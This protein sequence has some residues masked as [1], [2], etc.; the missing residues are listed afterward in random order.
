MTKSPQWHNDQH[1][2]INSAGWSLMYNNTLVIHIGNNWLI[3][4]VRQQDIAVEIN[5]INAEQWL[6]Y[7]VNTF[8]T[9]IHILRSVVS[10]VAF[11]RV[12]TVVRPCCCR[13]DNCE[14][15]TMT[16]LWSCLHRVTFARLLMTFSL[17]ES[18]LAAFLAVICYINWC[19]T[20]F[21]TSTS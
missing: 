20:Y 18:A 16:L 3:S 12:F 11:Y 4:F 21:F 2:H 17:S 15:A 10:L 7:T 19:V 14:L 5:A 8:S 1:R 6:Q 13:S 9:N